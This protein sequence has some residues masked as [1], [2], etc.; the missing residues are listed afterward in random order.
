M[1]AEM[2][3]AGCLL[4]LLIAGIAVGFDGGKREQAEDGRGYR[5]GSE[6]GG[7]RG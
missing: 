3:V 7:V 5:R 2:I 4:I 6:G 1:T